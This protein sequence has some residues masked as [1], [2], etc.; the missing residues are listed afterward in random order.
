[1]VK[2]IGNWYTVE[3]DGVEY[4]VLVQRTNEIECDPSTILVFDEKMD[5]VQ[6]YGIWDRIEFD[7]LGHI[8]WESLT[9]NK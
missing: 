1:M 8:E 3:L 2:R 7:V 5:K 9:L 6:D 4:N